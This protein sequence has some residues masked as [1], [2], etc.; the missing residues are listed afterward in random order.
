M[1]EKLSS[2]LGVFGIIFYF[3]ITLVVGVMPFVMINISSSIIRIVLFALYF[4][5]P[6]SSIIFW[7]WGLVCAIG[8]P[9]DILAIVYYILFVIL[10]LP[11]FADTLLSL[12][13][14]SIGRRK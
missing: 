3:V 14:A 6:S 13:S 10:F 9:Q 4:M 7:I 2:A 8:G 5:F 11:F 12:M 1:K